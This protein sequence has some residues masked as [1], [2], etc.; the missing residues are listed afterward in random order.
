MHP[1]RIVN[2]DLANIVSSPI[3]WKRFEN[4]TILISGAN[5]FLPAYIVETLLHLKYCGI[6]SD[7][8]IVALVRNIEKVKLKFAHHSENDSLEIIVA[9][10]SNLID[11]DKRIDFI[12]HAASQASPKYYGIDPVGT[13]K[14]NTLGTYNMLELARKHSIE[15]MLNFSSGEVYGQIENCMQI[16]ETDYGYTDICNVRACYGES[17][18]MGE[19]MCVAYAHQYGVPVKTV[20]P[21]HTYGPGMMLDDGR[22]FADFVGNVVRG[23]DIVMNSDGSAIRAFCYLTDA[24]KAFFTILLNG[25]NAESYNMGNPSQAFSI[26]ELAQIIIGLFPDKDIKLHITADKSNYLK[27]PISM[28]SPCI[29]K[30]KMLNWVPEVNAEDG[31][32]RTIESYI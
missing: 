2:Q 13:L 7:V 4:K 27:S 5:G 3:N 17:K 30:I 19:T 1:N 8:K 15:S 29:E 21:F 9:D 6:I 20:R 18:R 25:T 31:F 12:V 28:N 26:K 10:V 11:I 23:E 24:T 14:A 16:K 32:R 22:V